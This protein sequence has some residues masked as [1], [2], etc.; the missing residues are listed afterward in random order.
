[1]EITSRF[2]VFRQSANVLKRLETDF[3]HVA[4]GGGLQV[5]PCPRHVGSVEPEAL[6]NFGL[7]KPVLQA[8]QIG[9]GCVNVNDRLPRNLARMGEALVI[10]HPGR[11]ARVV[12]VRMNVEKPPL[13]HRHA[14]PQGLQVAQKPAAIRTS[15]RPACSTRRVATCSV[16]GG[17]LRLSCV[18][19]RHQATRQ[20]PR[21]RWDSTRD[22]TAPGSAIR[23][24]R[25][26]AMTVHFDPWHR[27]SQRARDAYPRPRN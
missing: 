6:S 20:T 27:V 23:S 26:F 8:I 4:L 12:M 9:M 24:Q 21:D 15:S 11:H 19:A 16:S 2:N 25:V 22:G 17:D 13:N 1:M 10:N 3:E 14:V 7:F 5:Q 18:H